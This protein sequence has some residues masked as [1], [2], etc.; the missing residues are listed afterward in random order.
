MAFGRAIWDGTKTL[1]DS[2]KV[3]SPEEE[4]PSNFAMFIA[5][6]VGLIFA[7]GLFFLL[8]SFLTDLV[9][10]FGGVGNQFVL[11]LIEGGIRLSLFLIYLLFVTVFKDIRR[12]FMYH[13]AE[14]KAINCLEKGLPL[15]IENVQTCST[16]HNR[17]GTTFLFFVMVVSILV[18]SL[19]TWLLGLMPGA[20]DWINNGFVR[21]GVRLVF[22]PFVAGLSY[23]LLRLIAKTPDNWFFLIFKAPGLALQKLSTRKPDNEMCEVAI[24]ALKAVMEMEKNP[25]KT[26]ILF[27]EVFVKEARADL[28]ADLQAAG[29]EAKEAD[30]I[31]RIVLGKEGREAVKLTKPQKDRLDDIVKRRLDREPLDLIVG[32]SYFYGHKVR[33]SK[34]V[35]L[36]RMETERVAEAV[37]K[38]INRRDGHQPPVEV[39]DIC[40]GSGCIALAVAK[41]T[42]AQ[43]TAADISESA[44]AIAKNN[45]ADTTVE[46]IQSDLFDNLQDRKF[47]IIVTN[48]PYISS[49]IIDTLE[50]EV[51]DHT[52][53]IALDGGE[54]G[55][56]FYRRILTEAKSH[57][58]KDGILI[59]EIG[60]DQGGAI[61]ELTGNNCEIINDYDG[62]DRVAVITFNQLSS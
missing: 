39:L 17:C 35:L 14:H 55:L 50:P 12:T 23:E 40:T 36:P 49:K 57:L 33:V 13:G 52:P 62:N 15:T 43:V 27:G 44:L 18:F 22:L 21:A 19:V 9:I 45:F 30:W 61:S 4:T 10:R 11:S 28:A 5:V 6:A 8:P 41:E 20:G 56:D 2:A 42:A 26:E 59:M 31:M 29:I 58:N 24:T 7:V 60:Y 32:Y 54:D 47:D 25:D 16:R 51:K 3:S 46:M 48:P 38:E 1:L 53:R 34:D 37:I